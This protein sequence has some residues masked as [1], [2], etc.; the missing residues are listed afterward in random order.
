MYR[1]YCSGSDMSADLKR[2][3][4]RVRAKRPDLFIPRTATSTSMDGDGKVTSTRIT[5]VEATPLN[6]RERHRLSME[7][8]R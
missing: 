4:A 7:I 1:Y 5:T 2:V 6:P 8:W 3:T